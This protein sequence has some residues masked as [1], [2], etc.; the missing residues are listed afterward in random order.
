VRARATLLGWASCGALLLWAGT[1][2]AT[3]DV[4]GDSGKKFGEDKEGWLASWSSQLPPIVATLT[5]RSIS[6]SPSAHDSFDGNVESSSL[7]YKFG[8]N[9]FGSPLRTFGA[10][11]GLFWYPTPFTYVGPAL[12]FG[13]GKYSG[14]SFVANALTIE[15]RDSL[16]VTTTAVGGVVGLRLPLGP[17]SLRGELFAGADFLSIDQYA[18][19]GSTLLTATSSATSFLLEPRA[20]VDL[21]ATPFVTVSL[22]GAMPSFDAR[23]M[24]G[25]IVLA[26]HLRAFDGRYGLF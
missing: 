20:A 12:G 1:T 15:P 22:F 5:L 6:Y 4:L 3:P 19:N 11:M 26:G 16:N 2:S 7:A 25:G 13:E 8:G 17:I 9:A 21:W 18:Q 23:A 14:G 24:D 10:E